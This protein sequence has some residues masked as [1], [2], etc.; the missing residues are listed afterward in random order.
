MHRDLI[1]VCHASTRATRLATFPA[2][3]PIDEAGRTR[4]VVAAT[5]VPGRGQ[6]W[7]APSLAARQTALACGLDAT[8][9]PAIRDCDFGRWAGRPVADVLRDEPDGFRA[10]MTDPGSAPHGGEPL[11]ALLARVGRWLDERRQARG[12]G[13]AVTHPAVVRAA[14]I[15][16][17]EA[18][19]ATFW[20]LDI[21]PL[22]QTCLRTDGRRWTLRS[23]HE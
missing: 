12:G 23:L 4:A 19:T 22:S 10:W 6:A 7:C 17:L 15:H 9:E 11:N 18:T 1:F 14:I 13:I 20:H 21:A 8:D 2:D 16:A 5:S 3:D